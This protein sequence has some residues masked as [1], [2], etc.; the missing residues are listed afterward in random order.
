MGRVNAILKFEHRFNLTCLSGDEKIK[1]PSDIAVQFSNEFLTFSYGLAAKRKTNSDS[2][3]LIESVNRDDR[4]IRLRIFKLLDDF[5]HNFN[6]VSSFGEGFFD[7]SN[8]SSQFLAL[9]FTRCNAPKMASRFHLSGL[10]Y[11]QW[12]CNFPCFLWTSL[13]NFPSLFSKEASKKCW[14]FSSAVNL[15]LGW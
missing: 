2:N 9:C 1:F 8:S 4:F 3:C 14:E 13:M 11:F 10:A 15:I 6:W 7:G 12:T 5:I